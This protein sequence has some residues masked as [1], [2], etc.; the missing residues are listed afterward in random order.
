M[1]DELCIKNHLNGNKLKV[2]NKNSIKSTVVSKGTIQLPPVG[3]PDKANVQTLNVSPDL[4]ATILTKLFELPPPLIHPDID[5]R[6]V[7]ADIEA[8][9][10]DLKAALPLSSI[11]IV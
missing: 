10:V 8:V 6:S 4:E 5:V 7:I 1:V 3:D 11:S 2:S 9:V